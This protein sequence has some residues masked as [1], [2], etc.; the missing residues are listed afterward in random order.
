MTTNI[1]PTAKSSGVPT[2]SQ[3]DHVNFKTL[4]KRCR[5]ENKRGVADSSESDV[6]PDEKSANKVGSAN[7]ATRF[8]RAACWSQLK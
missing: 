3:M 8:L 5:Q 4:W 2:E 6:G 7:V 1:I